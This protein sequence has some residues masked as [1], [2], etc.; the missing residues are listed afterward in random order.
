MKIAVYL[1][2]SPGKNPEYRARTEELG[3]WIGESG[4][5]LVY[6]GAKLGLMGVLAEAVREKNGTVI[7]VIPGF[8]AAKGAVYEDADQIEHTASMSM[9]KERMM[10]L[11][12]AYIAMP[13][14][15][16]TLEEIAEAISLSRLGRSEKECILYDIGGYYDD[17]R[18]LL[19]KMIDQGFLQPDE[20]AHV[21]FAESLGE[22]KEL[23]CDEA[24]AFTGKPS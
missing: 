12:D 23:L 11:A 22:I 5:T 14:G 7:G 16:G 18:R 21:H 2:S 1:G 9:R 15:V 17:L 20:L 13:G 10:E 24:E 8:I 19:L 3:H 4:H 6:G